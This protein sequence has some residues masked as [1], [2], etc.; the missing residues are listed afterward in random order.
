MELDRCSFL[1]HTL[2]M[3]KAF[4]DI[5]RREAKRQGLSGY[6]LAKLVAP[7]VSRRMVQAYLAGTY[8]MTGEKLQAV[9]EAL[10][11]ELRGRGRRKQK[12]G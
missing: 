3:G 1:H 11:L 4:R 2:V 5:I 7:A 12:G 6:A 8:D 10:G 9:C